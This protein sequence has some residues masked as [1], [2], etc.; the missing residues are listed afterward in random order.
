MY[1]T[2]E[3]LV[4]AIMSIPH[5]M[6]G[7]NTGK[8]LKYVSSNMTLKEAGKRRKSP[9]V[10]MLITDSTAN[11]DV[12]SPAYFL[13]EKS[14]VVVVGVGDETRRSELDLI[15]SKPSDTF[16]HSVRGFEDLKSAVGNVSSSICDARGIL[17]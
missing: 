17:C 13:Q 6:G 2:K 9:M 7:S 4:E 8:A 10:T 14:S 15:A 1:I 11:D 5:V 12:T 3:S 16:V